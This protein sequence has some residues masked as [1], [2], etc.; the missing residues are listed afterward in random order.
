MTTTKSYSNSDRF[1]SAYI[2]ALKGQLPFAIVSGIIFLILFVVVF[3][4]STADIY[5]P[6]TAAEFFNYYFTQGIYAGVEQSIVS[7]IV[8]AVLALTSTLVGLSYL[9]SKKTVDLYHSLPISRPK[10]LGANLL[11]TL[12]AVLGPYLAMYL[13]TMTIQLITCARYGCFGTDYFLFILF[14]I[15]AAIV[16]IVVITAFTAF[17]TVNVGTVFDAFAATMALGF[18]PPLIYMLGGYIWQ[19]LV[20]GAYFEP[21]ENLLCLSPF[22]FIYKIWLLIAD[23]T[24]STANYGGII[25]ERCGPIMTV[26]LLGLLAAALLLVA[27]IVCYR[28][29]KSEIAE[30]TQPR[31]VL[32]I[33]VKLAAAFIGGSVFFVIFDN[34]DMAE[35]LTAGLVF[36]T[37]VGAVSIGLIAE[38][39]LSRG[40]RWILRNL[41]WVLGA[42]VV[43]CLLMIG[44]NADMFGYA[45]R[46]PSLDSIESAQ[47]NYTGRFAES[48]GHPQMYDNYGSPLTDAE[49]IA[50]VRETHNIAVNNRPP[51]DFRYNYSPDF[52]Y[53][54][55]SIKYKLKNGTTMSRTYGRPYVGA[56]DKLV[57]LESENDFIRAKS[58]LFWAE[59]NPQL[60]KVNTV[61][62]YSSFGRK[63]GQHANVL[64]NPELLLNAIKADMLDQSLDDIINPQNPALGFIRVNFTQLDPREYRS[65]SYSGPLYATVTVTREYKRTL[66]VLRQLELNGNFADEPPRFDEIVKVDMVTGWYFGYS[67]SGYI[68]TLNPWNSNDIPYRED[69]YTQENIITTR[70]DAPGIKAIAQVSRDM[71]FMPGDQ[72][73]GTKCATAFFEMTDGSVI[74]KIVKLDDLPPDIR[75]EVRKSA[76]EV[77]KSAE[78]SDK[79]V[80]IAVTA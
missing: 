21:S 45:S 34:G 37:L 56:N 69:Y 36:F 51:K 50:I 80:T 32:Q 61:E 31:G 54:S 40:I 52:G 29:R 73:W 64:D 65:F 1:G 57:E 38:I 7:L 74:A 30:Q 33:I 67:G 71:L 44:I 18:A 72:E 63:G 75:D 2:A 59:Q 12:T 43:Y 58:M 35:G 42:G 5:E 13:L 76:S 4:I 11:A 68:R 23:R 22:M 25:I 53:N 39:I 14:D 17:I 41:K 9:H 28:R 78:T 19:S 26:L 6:E 60:T 8:L 27:A 10:L 62:L 46:V 47:V 66:E 20:Y 3:F 15:M 16:Y 48:D 49:S 55:I 70:T 24:Y 79:E 77:Y